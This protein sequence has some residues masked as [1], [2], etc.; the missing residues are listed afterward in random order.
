M[1]VILLEDVKSLGKK[2]DVVEV[3][4]KNVY[5]VKVIKLIK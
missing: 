5:F 2:D 4:G 1:K 3:K